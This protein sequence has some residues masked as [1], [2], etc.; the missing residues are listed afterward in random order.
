LS[1][2]NTVRLAGKVSRIGALKYTPSGVAIREGQLAVNQKTLGKESVGYYDLLFFG[3]IA[4]R[5]V[6]AIRV[7]TSLLVQGSLWSRAY[8]NRKGVKVTE[9][10]VVVESFERVTASRPAPSKEKP[11]NEH[12]Q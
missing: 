6:E 2:L 11:V 9:V 1:K 5:E 8:R 3:E 12:S 10:K 7:G 4:E